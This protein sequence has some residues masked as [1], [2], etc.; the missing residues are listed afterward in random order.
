MADKLYQ[1]RKENE[2][3]IYPSFATISSFA[4][5]GA[6]IHYQPTTKTNKKIIGNSLYLVDSGVNITKIRHL[7]PQISQEQLLLVKQVKK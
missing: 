2:E 6:I 5:N 3:F 4:S 1:F 7:E